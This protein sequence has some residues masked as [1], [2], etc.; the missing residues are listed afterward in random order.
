MTR[1]QLP[2]QIKK[3]SVTDRATGK[4]VVRY[5]VVVDAGVDP[6]TKKRKQ[7]RR[8]FTT[9][10]AARDE[11]AAVLGGVKAGTYVHRSGATVDEVCEAWLLSK[12]NLKASTIAGH[13]SKL[14]VL[15]AEL[16]NI[17]VQ[18]LSKADLDNLVGLLRAGE[19]KG[20]RRPWTPR[21]VNYLLYLATAVL[22]D[23][24]AQGNVVR[25]VAHLVDRIPANPKKFRTLT[26]DEMYRILDHDCRD[27][28]LWT[29]ALYGLRR[30]ELAGLRWCNVNLTDKTVGHGDD[31][32]PARHLRVV[33]NRVT[34]GST[35]STGT[36]KSKASKRTLPLPDDVVA[37]LKAARKAQAQEQLQFGPGY[38]EGDYVARD[39][40]GKPYYP[41][42][43]TDRWRD[44][45]KAMKIDH[46]RLHD[47]RHTCGTLMHL[48]GV[49]IAVI[50]AWLGHHSPA[51]TMA[52]YAHSQDDALK[53]AAMSFQRVVTTRD[54]QTGPGK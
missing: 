17:E 14:K 7:I 2:P 19:A 44:M 37:V 20:C 9:E 1:Q 48:Q 29:L 25:N 40:T 10:K 36:P 47:A 4:P 21:S 12:H 30:G 41:G 32:I 27:R 18:R 28:H 33:E 31:A 53:A 34:F 54:T 52:V 38:G 45:L 51:F 49:P 15:R 39:V 16:G 5:Q 13:R 6:E 3:I 43:L 50:A 8:R 24:L 23:Q 22:E 26:E 42:V 35:V 46:V 11:L